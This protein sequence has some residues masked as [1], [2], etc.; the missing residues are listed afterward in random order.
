MENGLSPGGECGFNVDLRLQ[1]RPICECCVPCCIHFDDAPRDKRLLAL[2]LSF[3]APRFGQPS[4][5]AISLAT[6]NQ[7]APHSSIGWR[8]G[9]GGLGAGGITAVFISATISPTVMARL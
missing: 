5:G 3:P 2:A 8:T 4:V 6:R 7:K 9:G 1:S